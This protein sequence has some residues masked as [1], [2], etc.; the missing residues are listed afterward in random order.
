MLETRHWDY[1]PAGDYNSISSPDGSAHER[2]RLFPKGDLHAEP[3]CILCDTFAELLF[4]LD[5]PPRPMQA[6]R[7]RCGARPLD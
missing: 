3:R 5:P 7:P 1:A 4:G 2:W 6:G